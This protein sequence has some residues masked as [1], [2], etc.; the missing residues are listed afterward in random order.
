SVVV[1]FAITGLSDDLD[2]TSQSLA[3]DI[4]SGK[5]DIEYPKGT[6]WK[7]HRGSIPSRV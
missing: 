7:A 4:G 2:K 6:V 5:A 3:N 1:D